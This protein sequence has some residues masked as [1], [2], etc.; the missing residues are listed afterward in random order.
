MDLKSKKA[1]I[2]LDVLGWTIIGAAVLAIMVTA[3]ILMR[4]QGGSAIDFIK[5]LFRFGR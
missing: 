3:Y 4:Y 1:A 2:E 5:N